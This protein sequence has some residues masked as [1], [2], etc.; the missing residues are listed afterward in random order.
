MLPD[1]GFV[2]P[3]NAAM[4]RLTLVNQYVA[5]FRKVEVSTYNDA[6]SVLKN[7][8]ANISTL[9]V[10]DKQAALSTLVDSQ[11]SKLF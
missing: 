11:M 8:A 2:A 7:L 1:S 3:Q 6:K 9:V 4:Q 5:A 10:T